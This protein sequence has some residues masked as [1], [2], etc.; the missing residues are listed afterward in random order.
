MG[1][2]E[3]GE[4]QMTAAV[5]DEDVNAALLAHSKYWTDHNQGVRGGTD[6]GA[7]R[8]A[9]LAASA[10]MPVAGWQTMAC[11]ALKAA[12]VDLQSWVDAHV[13]AGFVI[14]TESEAA[15]KTIDAALAAA[16]LPQEEKP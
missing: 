8:A 7:M 15:L 14:P 11:D 1:G 9:L 12:R 5:S 2:V 16:P 6:I 4:A 10:H 13:S 3:N